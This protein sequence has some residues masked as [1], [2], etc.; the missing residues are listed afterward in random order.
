MSISSLDDV[1]TFKAYE[2]F[3]REINVLTEKNINNIEKQ[4]FVSINLIREIY[5]TIEI[6]EDSIRESDYKCASR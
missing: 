6:R 5:N 2:Q 1:I 4:K 3:I